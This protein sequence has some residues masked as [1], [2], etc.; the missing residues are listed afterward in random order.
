LT[1]M[2]PHTALH[3]L[4]LH[5]ALPI[6]DAAEGKPWVGS[7]HR[8]HEHLARL[9]VGHETLALSVVVG[10][11]T[12]AEAK[13]RIVGERDSLV[14]VAHAERSEEHTSELQSR[15]NLLCRLLLE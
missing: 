1:I 4:C 9:D 15:E 12:G 2:P 11:H 5:D 3:T 8:V 14:D 13:R 7:N 6:F 10:P